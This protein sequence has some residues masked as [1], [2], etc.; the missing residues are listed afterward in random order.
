MTVA[1]VVQPKIPKTKV[2][3][4][5]HFIS[6]GILELP[7]YI[8]PCFC[9]LYHQRRFIM[10]MQQWYRSVVSLGLAAALSGAVSC[11]DDSQERLDHF[12]EGTVVEE[13]LYSFPVDPVKVIRKIGEKAERTEDY[14][15]ADTGLA[16][17]VKVEAREKVWDDEAKAQRIVQQTYTLTMRDTSSAI[18]PI[19]L[20]DEQIYVGTVVVFRTRDDKGIPLYPVNRAGT[21][22]AQE[23]RVIQPYENP[24]V[25]KG[26]SEGEVQVN[27]DAQKKQEQT[28]R[29]KE[30]QEFY[31]KAR[32]KKE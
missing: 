25:I 22:D 12:V 8:L 15:R 31:N 5:V 26:G 32:E 30:A 29:Y 13:K 1:G 23:V 4:G 10:T 6:R 17:V 16:C 11:K 28:Q 3:G 21:I 27:L 14:E 18:V 2:L 7:F 19:R 24:A 20:L 9:F